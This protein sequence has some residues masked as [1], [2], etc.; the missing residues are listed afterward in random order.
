MK[1]LIA[2][3]PERCCEVYRL[4]HIEGMEYKEI[5]TA[6]GIPIGTVMS[7]LHRAGKKMRKIVADEKGLVDKLA[8]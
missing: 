7:R 3:L 8:A 4:F 1:K 2:L 5:A 6:L